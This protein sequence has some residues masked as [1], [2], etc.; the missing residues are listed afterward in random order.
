MPS[1]TNKKVKSFITCTHYTYQQSK[2]TK[3]TS[4]LSHLSLASGARAGPTVSVLTAT[5]DCGTGSTLALNGEVG[6]SLSSVMGWSINQDASK[7]TFWA[8]TSPLIPVTREIK[9]DILTD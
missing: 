9:N 5:E 3:L 4:V 2:A 1:L 7:Q 8:V 6:P